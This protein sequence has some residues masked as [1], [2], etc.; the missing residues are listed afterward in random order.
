MSC[1]PSSTRPPSRLEIHDSVSRPMGRAKAPSIAS[2][3]FYTSSTKIRVF[4][5]LLTIQ[6]RSIIHSPLQ[7]HSYSPTCVSSLVGA[8]MTTLARDSM[9]ANTF[10]T[11]TDKPELSAGYCLW[12]ATQGDRVDFLRG[13]FS[14]ATVSRC[15]L[16]HRAYFV[17]VR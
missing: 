14:S 12:L 5:C 17:S 4:E 11:L 13:R 7:D 2:Q 6:V 9:P 10:A 16:I 1:R 15:L 8:I 3:S